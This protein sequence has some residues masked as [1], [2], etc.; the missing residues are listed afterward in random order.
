MARRIAT[1]L[2]LVLALSGVAVVAAPAPAMAACADRFP[3]LDWQPVGTTDLISVEA[4]GL[5]DA[6]GLRF[7]EE[8]GA[9]A[10]LLEED[11]GLLPALE[12]CAYAAGLRLDPTGLVAP[13]QQL[14]AAVF[15]ESG[16]VFVGGFEL[17]LFDESHSFGLAYAVL[18]DVA[19]QL[20][21]DAYPEPLAT[22]VG[23]WYLSRVA[24]KLELHHNQMRDGA[25][26]RD[27]SGSGIEATSWAV[28]SQPQVY[29][30]NPQFQESPLSDLVEYAVSEHGVEIL[31]RPDGET[32]AGIERD[33]QEAL[34]DEA[35]QGRSSGNAWLVGATIFLGFV[36]L[37]VATAWVTKRSRRRALERLR[38]DSQTSS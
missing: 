28:S 32:W 23:Q 30:W 29:T 6:Q 13:G 35:L 10:R 20:G 18:W 16:S 19:A 27:P 34:R 4:A 3:D 1:F 26:F 7:A 37:A 5:S 31:R 17:G 38:E 36:A 11:F 24:G 22:V 15:N 21:L 25:F 14:H 9:T 12:L 2:L 33:W 8:A